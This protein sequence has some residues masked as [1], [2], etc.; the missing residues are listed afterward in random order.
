[1]NWRDFSYRRLVDPECKDEDCLRHV[2]L[3]R[4]CTT[5]AEADYFLSPARIRT[6]FENA[7]SKSFVVQYVPNKTSSD[8]ILQT[9]T[10]QGVR[11]ELVGL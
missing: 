11:A 9:V 7:F 3:Y 10:S 6:R 1:M 2:A 8:E 5:G 4:G